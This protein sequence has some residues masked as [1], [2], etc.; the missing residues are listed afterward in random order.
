[1]PTSPDNYKLTFEQDMANF[2]IDPAEL[3]ERFEEWAA[4]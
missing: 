1:M 3:A 4:S 2:G